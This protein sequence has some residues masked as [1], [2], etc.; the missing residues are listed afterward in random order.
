VG[1]S[2]RR[3]GHS[4]PQPELPEC[5][6]LAETREAAAAFWIGRLRGFSSKLQKERLRTAHGLENPEV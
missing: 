4:L 5:L 1:G 2:A 3:P 6:R